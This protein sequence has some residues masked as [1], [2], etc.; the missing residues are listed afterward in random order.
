LP[1]PPAGKQCEGLVKRAS[2]ELVEGLEAALPHVDD[3]LVDAHRQGWVGVADEIHRPP[4]RQVEL[5][6]DRG[7]RAPQ[8]VWRAPRDL[9][10]IAGRQQ[11]VGTLNRRVDD[12]APHVVN[13]VA[14][15]VAGR[16]CRVVSAVAELGLVVDE[17]VLERWPHRHH[18][19]G[20]LGLD[21][22]TRTSWPL[23]SLRRRGT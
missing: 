4:W 5:R 8:R 13:A 19:L 21:P 23:R 10:L 12:R 20:R 17:L 15:S 7:E 16:E 11:R 22:C 1:N 18:A 2:N 3:L 6:E 9:T 14:P